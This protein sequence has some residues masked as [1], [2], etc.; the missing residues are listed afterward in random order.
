M[1]ATRVMTLL[2]RRSIATV[3]ALVALATPLVYEAYM[4]SVAATFEIRAFSRDLSDPRRLAGFADD[5]FVGRV[6]GEGRFYDLDS[7]VN[8]TVFPVR[9]LEVLKGDVPSADILVN[10]VGGED[11]YG[12]VWRIEGVP[13]LQPSETYLFATRSSGDDFLGETATPGVGHTLLASDDQ[14]RRLVRRFRDAIQS[15]IPYD[16]PNPARSDR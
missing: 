6:E 1:F 7:T 8:R 16:V 2:G 4:R 5:V 9:V 14:R 13:M 10:Q 15:A 3:L 12:N 11:Q